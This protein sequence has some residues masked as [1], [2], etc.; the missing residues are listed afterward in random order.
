MPFNAE[1]LTNIFFVHTINDM[2]L[3]F[4]P[5]KDV[6]NLAKH[7]VSLADA[8]HLN[9]EQALVWTDTRKNYGE[10]R[11]SALAVWNERVFFVAFVERAD[12]RRVISFRKANQREFDR[13]V[14]YL[15]SPN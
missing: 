7:G 10:I 13:Y 11:Q 3:L 9:W 5:S 1:T 15:D 8:A 4:D 2:N 6:A 14:A 12:G